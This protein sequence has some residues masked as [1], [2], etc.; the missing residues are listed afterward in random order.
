MKVR[1][2]RVKRLK[3]RSTFGRSI[4]A[5]NFMRAQMQHAQPRQARNPAHELV[6]KFALSNIQQF[7]A[8]RVRDFA[9]NVVAVS[10][11]ELL[12]AAEVAEAGSCKAAANGQL[13]RAHAAQAD[14]GRVRQVAA[15]EVV[16]NAAE[17]G[18]KARIVP[19]DNGRHSGV[20]EG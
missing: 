14:G 19:A 8:L 7:Q 12:Q 18:A 20:R 11:L 4:G 15:A 17:I 1:V 13:E 9:A 10:Q 2:S 6:A 3:E 5:A 16:A